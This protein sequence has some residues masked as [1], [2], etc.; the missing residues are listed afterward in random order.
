ML[1]LLFAAPPGTVPTVPIGNGL[2]LPMVNLGT[3]SGQHGDVMNATALWLQAGGTG[4]DTAY[5]YGNEKQIAQGI[6][7]AG[8][9]SGLFI[10]TKILCGTKR[11]AKSVGIAASAKPGR[12]EST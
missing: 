5:M 3:G 8:S 12:R 10:T 4:I 9:P 6:S 1:P 7:A 11:S 2:K